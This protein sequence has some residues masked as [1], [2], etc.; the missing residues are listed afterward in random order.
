MPRTVALASNTAWY[1]HN[2]RSGLIRTLLERGDRVA[3][4]APSDGYVPRLRDMGCEVVDLPMDNMGTNPVRD[5]ATWH[6]FRRAYRAIG[7]EVVLHYTAKPMVYGTLAA[8]SLGIPIVNTVTGLGTAFLRGGPLQTVVQTLYRVALRHSPRVFFQNPDDLDLFVSRGLVRLE[9]A[10]RLPGSGVDLERFA[11]APT[12]QGPARVFLLVARMLR[13]KGIGE[14]V[15]AARGLRR[16]NPGL[17]FQLLGQL[18]VANRTAI[19]R[20]EVESWVREGSI[21]HLGEIDDVRPWIGNADCVVLPSYR[22]GTP[23]TLLEA[24]AMGRPIVTTDVPGCRQ[25]VDD[26]VTGLLCRARD[27][28][29]LAVKIRSITGM[30]SEQRQAM[31]L[32]GRAKMER[33]FDQR[34]VIAGYLA[35]IEEALGCC[36]A[37]MFAASRLPGRNKP[38]ALEDGASADQSAQCDVLP[39]AHPSQ[40]CSGG[41][42]A[43]A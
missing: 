42:T 28:T 23:R 11:V 29:D 9:Q 39:R 35:A 21:E 36:E 26:G 12:A 15:E 5:I 20:S 4:L 38:L 13:D 27:A 8:R 14:F 41:A 10:G 16:E 40:S 2:F 22:E 33:E 3:T 34:I 6:H 1:L 43:D 31:G 32:A 24:A 25:V 18:G 7:P 17:R 30:T 19:P 37:K